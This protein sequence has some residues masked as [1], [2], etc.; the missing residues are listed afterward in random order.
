VLVNEMRMEDPEA[1]E[2]PFEVTVRYRRDRYGS[3][4]EFQC[5]ENDRNPIDEEG[6]TQFL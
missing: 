2:E 4:I 6:H 5:A 1:L 3:L